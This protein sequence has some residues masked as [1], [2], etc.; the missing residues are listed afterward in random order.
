[1]K[2]KDITSTVQA[3]TVVRLI[4]LVISLINL[5]LSLFSTY[6][7]PGLT[8]EAQDSL[9]IL[10]TAV[11]SFVSY[12]YN[13]SWSESATTAD[14]LL[15]MLKETDVTVDDAIDLINALQNKVDDRKSEKEATETTETDDTSKF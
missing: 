7:I 4:V 15:T 10:F 6:Q 8:A 3:K 13:N 11:A 9:A 14:K 2:L 12:W 1:M 5:G